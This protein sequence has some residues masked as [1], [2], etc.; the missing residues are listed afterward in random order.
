MNQIVCICYCQM[1][2]ELWLNYFHFYWLASWERC[3][4][5]APSLLFLGVSS[6]NNP[7]LILEV[8]RRKSSPS[9]VLPLAPS[10]V[11][12]F[13]GDRRWKGGVSGAMFDLGRVQDYLCCGRSETG[14]LRQPAPL[15]VFSFLL[16]FTRLNVM[17]PLPHLI[18]LSD[19][20]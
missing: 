3:W 13:V 18:P 2:T 17:P 19:F 6:L 5:L 16:A 15:H 4:L 9:L 10:S 12:L 7:L 8:N 1:C 11:Y 14:W 20:L